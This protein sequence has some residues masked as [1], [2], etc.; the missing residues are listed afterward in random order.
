M[1]MSNLAQA[2]EPN[3]IMAAWLN[4]E[5]CFTIFED[6]IRRK[7]VLYLRNGNKTLYR[8]NTS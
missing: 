8:G 7:G 2:K 6:K 5:S 4:F 1:P 3:R